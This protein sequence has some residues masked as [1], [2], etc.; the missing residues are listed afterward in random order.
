MTSSTSF[1][2]YI[3]EDLKRRNWLTALVA[4]GL[5]IV[6]P[7][8]SMVT[9]ENAIMSGSL[10]TYNMWQKAWFAGVIGGR[11][12]MPLIFGTILAAVLAG[13]TGFSWLHSK[14]QVDFYH[15]LPVERKKWFLTSYVSGLCIYSIPYVIFSIVTTVIWMIKGGVDITLMQIAGSIAANILGY[16]LLYSV[17]ILAMMLSG[18]IVVGVL[19]SGVFMV[20]GMLLA[21]VVRG[22]AQSFLGTA[23]EIGYGQSFWG[24]ISPM[25]LFM[26]LISG[27]SRA[28]KLSWGMTAYIVAFTAALALIALWLYCKRPSEAAQQSLAFP[29]MAGAVK[30]LIAVPTALYAGLFLTSVSAG[31]YNGKWVIVGSAIGIILLCMI[32]EFIYHQDMQ[33][34]F[35]GKRSTIL[36][37]VLVILALAVLKFDLIGYDTYLPEKE[38]IE[39]MSMYADEYDGYFDRVDF[40]GY[41]MVS[42]LGGGNTPIENFDAIYALA[43]QG[44]EN[45][46]QKIAVDHASPF[47]ETSEY[48]EL[49]VRYKLK[50]GRNVYRVYA[51][52]KEMIIDALEELCG[53]SDYRQRLFPVFQLREDAIQRISVRDIRK[54]NVTMNLN[55]NQMSDLLN[56]YKKDVQQ[57]SIEELHSTQPIGEFIMDVEN[58][59]DPEEYRQISMFYIYEDYEN[60]KN[61][62]EGQK[63]SLQTNL[64]RQ[65]VVSAAILE[66]EEPEGTGNTRQDA[67]YVRDE[68]MWKALTDETEIE[69]MLGSV[70]YGINGLLGD[71]IDPSKEVRIVGSDGEMNSYYFLKE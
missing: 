38:E 16:M 40:E 19:A 63:I 20:Y 55:K 26:Y 5:L 52:E 18:K 12:N 25:E 51:V 61:F 67:S 65:D 49:A 59:G 2:N 24:M 9:V 71:Q 58:K 32:I 13:V 11:N 54:Q 30:V 22:L 39:S 56:A 31:D 35:G 21:T 68:S 27:I 6:L 15:S 29:K 17:T 10:N 7:V 66:Y 43:G 33:K 1:L 60:T 53:T 44:V 69:N 28:G 62:L 46:R 45:E 70:C 23:V 50:S 48:T 4:A 14:V 64:H 47:S 41:N 36:S 42:R 8:Y 37:I 34:I 3:K 57:V